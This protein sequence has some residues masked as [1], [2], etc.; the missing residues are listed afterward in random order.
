MFLHAEVGSF[1]FLLNVYIQTNALLV[2][3]KYFYGVI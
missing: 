1:L 2:T 3:L